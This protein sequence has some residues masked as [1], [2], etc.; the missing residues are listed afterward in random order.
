MTDNEV[1]PTI[2]KLLHE[3]RHHFVT[4]SDFVERHLDLF[5]LR[6]RNPINPKLSL[7]AFRGIVAATS[8]RLDL[9]SLERWNT[10]ELGAALHDLTENIEQANAL[11]VSQDELRK[12]HLRYLRWALFGGRHGPPI[13]E[14]MVYLGRKAAVDRLA[15]AE[16]IWREQVPHET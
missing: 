9:I 11:K 4:I 5:Y 8:S 2:R 10:H 7:P 6:E 3:Q 1:E 15:S 14:S 12:F 13:L 16:K